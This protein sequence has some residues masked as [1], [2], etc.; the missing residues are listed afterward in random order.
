MRDDFGGLFALGPATLRRDPTSAEVAGGLACGASGKD[1]WNEILFTESSIL[2][3]LNTILDA[4]GIGPDETRVDQLLA[5]LTK[6]VPAQ[7]KSIFNVR[8]FQ[9]NTRVSAAGSNAGQQTVVWSG[10]TYTKKSATSLVLCWGNFQ[11]AISFTPSGNTGPYG[12]AQIALTLGTATSTFGI[13]NS[14]PGFSYFNNFA[15]VFSNPGAGD[16][17][18]SV[19]LQRPDA[20]PWTNVFN[21]TSGADSSGT[22]PAMNVAT[23][24]F[25]EVEPT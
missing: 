13:A 20:N 11:T 18:I 22:F 3:E 14:Y 4:A 23:L 17:P 19:G 1:F 9:T 21:P 8:Q 6:I 25:A 16:R 24:I 10:I 15:Q 7:S 2:S 12:A 5:A